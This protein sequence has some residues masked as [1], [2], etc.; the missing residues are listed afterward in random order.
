MFIVLVLPF[1]FSCAFLLYKKYQIK[2]EV[3]ERILKGIERKY[4]VY[5]HFSEQTFN[6]VVSSS[7]EFYYQGNMYDLVELNKVGNSYHCWCWLDNEESDLGRKL[8]VLVDQSMGDD[9]ENEEG[10]KK[11]T[12][13]FKFLYYHDGFDWSIQQIDVIHKQQSLYLLNSLFFHQSRLLLPPE[14]RS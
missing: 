5:F 7:E 1:Y 14:F 10:K 11:L 12:D 13:W 6:D 9:T 3:K 8:S 2:S 4:L